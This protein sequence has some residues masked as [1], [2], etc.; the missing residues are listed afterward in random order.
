[1]ISFDF[2][3]ITGI[4]SDF[5][6][7]YC[8]IESCFYKIQAPFFGCLF[9]FNS[10]NKVSKTPVNENYR[11][12]IQQTI[13]YLIFNG[14]PEHYTDQLKINGFHFSFSMKKKMSHTCFKANYFLLG[15]LFCFVATFAIVALE[16]VQQQ[17]IS[18]STKATTIGPICIVTVIQCTRPP[19]PY[20][21][22]CFYPL[23]FFP[24]VAIFS[25]LLLHFI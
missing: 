12:F 1:M 7:S 23:L 8:F 4:Y 5:L 18:T 21:T 17:R 24:L 20:I 11:A 14:L 15:I 22:L 13:K 2:D 19:N 10:M 6:I 25:T 9:R 16:Y 3:I